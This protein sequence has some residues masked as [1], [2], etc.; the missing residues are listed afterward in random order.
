MF[1]T[2][3]TELSVDVAEKVDGGQVSFLG[4]IPDEKTVNL[5]C[6]L[7]LLTDLGLFQSIPGLK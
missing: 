7:M 1:P 4:I 5:I 3:V 6:V 2:L